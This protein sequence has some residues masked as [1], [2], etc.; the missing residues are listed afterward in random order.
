MV[1]SSDSEGD[2]KGWT[3]EANRHRAGQAAARYAEENDDELWNLYRCLIDKCVQEGYPF[4][5]DG[6]L[7]YRDFVR[8]ALRHANF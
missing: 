4:F 7:D 3:L 5:V 1:W 8:F 6:R 2:D